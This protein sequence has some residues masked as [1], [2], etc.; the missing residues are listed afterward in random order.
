MTVTLKSTML[1]DVMACICL[2][3]TEVSEENTASVFTI[4]EYVKQAASF[5]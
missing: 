4:K 2:K 1:W 5:T 3:F